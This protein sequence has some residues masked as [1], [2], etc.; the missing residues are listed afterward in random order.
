MQIPIS[1][2]LVMYALAYITN[3]TENIIFSIY[4]ALDPFFT[5]FEF[6]QFSMTF[7]LKSHSFRDVT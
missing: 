6:L 7:I 1:V 5:P 3:Y 4:L 2:V